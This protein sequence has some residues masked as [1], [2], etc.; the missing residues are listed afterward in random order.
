MIKILNL[1]RKWV[2]SKSIQKSGHPCLKNIKNYV[3]GNV[4]ELSI[5]SYK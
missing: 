5:Q 1:D 4:V 3:K 2:L